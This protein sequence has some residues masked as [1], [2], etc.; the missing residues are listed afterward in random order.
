MSEPMDG[1]ALLARIKPTLR[2]ESTQ[3]CLRPDLFEAWEEANQALIESRMK[4]RASQRLSSSGDSTATKTLAKK[5]QALEAEIAEH[6]IT[7]RFRAL[8][9]DKWQALC[10]RHAPRKGNEL[11]LFAGYNRDA[12]ID[13]AVRV[14]LVDPVFD[15]VSWGEFLEVVNPAEWN[16]LRTVVNQ[17]NRAGGDLPKSELASQILSKRGSGS[18]SA[19]SGE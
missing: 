10:D 9:K 6:A 19:A 4:D 11:D 5:V 16:E 8:P 18:R 13:A 1:R 7:F 14:C 12:V 3:L 15:D 2:E 17:V